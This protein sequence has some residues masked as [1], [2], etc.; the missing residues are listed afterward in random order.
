[1]PISRETSWGAASIRFRV[2]FVSACLFCCLSALC[3]M[4]ACMCVCVCADRFQI[5]QQRIMIGIH[6]YVRWF[7][8]H[9]YI[10]YPQTAEERTLLINKYNQGSLCHSVCVCVD[11]DG[12]VLRGTG[13]VRTPQQQRQQQQQE[14]LQEQQQEQQQLGRIRCCCSLCRWSPSHS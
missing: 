10:T 7:L 9:S 1:M 6:G 2:S 4:R 3:F 14:Q 13:K 12:D 11:V 8:R 5:V